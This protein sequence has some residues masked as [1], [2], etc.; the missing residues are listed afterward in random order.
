M[1]T[2]RGLLA[3]VLVSASLVSLAVA[4]P[5]HARS[6]LVKR[7]DEIYEEYDFIVVGA[8]TAGL[9]VA[10]RLSEEGKYT[11]L[12]IEY[13]YLDS[14]TTITAIG[15]GPRRDTLP[16]AT[17]YYNITSIPQPGLANGRKPAMAGAVVG[18]SSAVN[19]MFFDRGSAEDYD[20]W[21][22]VAGEWQ[23][24]FAEEWG[25]ENILPYF[26]KSVTFHPPTEE[27][28]EAY[29]MT[30]DVEGAYGGS[31]GIHSS[32]A[33]YQWDVQQHIWEGFKHIDGVDF[34][35]EGADGHAVGVF[36][37]PNSIDPSTRTRSYSKIGHYD[38]L[39][40]PAYRQNFHLLT[41][42]RVTQVLLEEAE[43]DDGNVVWDATGV[44][45]TPRDGPM[46]SSAWRVK[47]R[48]EVVV[49]AGALHSPQVL[50]RSGIGGRDIL[51]AAGVTP[52]VVLPGVGWNFQDHPNYG[53]SFRW[54]K[55]DLGP[56]PENFNQDKNFT[57]WADELWAAN[58][59]GPHAAYVNS[60]AFLPLS[61]L[62][63][64]YADIASAIAS[65]K[66]EDHLPEGLDPTIYAGYQQQL[67][68]LSQTYN[69]TGTA[70]LELPFS[71][72]SSFSL[73]NLH[74]LSRGSVHISPDDDGTT[75]TGRGDVEPVVDYRTLVNPIDNEVN[76]IFVAFVRSFFGS[77]YMVENLAPV[78]LTP[79]IDEYPDG[80][81]ELDGWLRR[82]LSPST[83]HPVGT[84]SLA[85]L[86]LGGVVGPDLRVYGTRRLSVAD[87]SVMPLIPGTHTS[88]TAYAIGEKA[89]DLIKR[90]AGWWDDAEE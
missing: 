87:N 21:F 55:E 61:V 62:T 89:A 28:V 45:F 2:L 34:P 76:A 83:G 9:T 23:E 29:G 10:D 14:S 6:A 84:C 71:G 33:P 40:G 80:S 74:E 78:E 81:E 90:R 63:P 48:K 85:P 59:T 17:R 31:A 79:G 66:A 42:H 65:Q 32:Y 39:D 47:A 46:P 41:G 54:T 72:R 56:T 7:Q 70:I 52:K 37:C 44:M 4:R 60:G 51:E 50:E 27:E 18:G 43:D 16:S 11:V 35:I 49:S 82:V 19:G 3:S 1:M 12:C 24:D 75:D 20:T 36:W 88:S 69:S 5:T 64:D 8:G 22:G 13:G 30:Y 58:Q 67:K 26:K 68:V 73:V 77:E 57:A 15:P 53:M 86:E 25:W 38:T